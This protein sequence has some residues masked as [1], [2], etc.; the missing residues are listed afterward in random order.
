MVAALVATAL[1]SKPVAAQHFPFCNPPACLI[2]PGCC[3][4]GACSGFCENLIP[5]SVAHC[6]D[7]N[8]GCCS[9][10]TPE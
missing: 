6:S 9:C 4:D 2:G 1:A 8:G 5:G 10:E 3:T 7:P